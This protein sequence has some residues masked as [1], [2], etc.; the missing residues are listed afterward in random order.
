MVI[1]GV[2][3]FKDSGKDTVADI[4][5]KYTGYK[6]V[7]M[8]SSLKD[9]V[10]TMFNWDRELLE[11]RT[12][13]SRRWREEVDD[14]WTHLIAS[15]GIFSNDS[16]I[17]PRIALQRI[18]N[19]IRTNISDDFFVN[20]SIMHDNIVISDARHMNELER[21]HITIRVERFSYSN[22]EIDKMD[23]SEK[24]HLSFTP[25]FI[26]SNNGGLSQLEEKV[27]SILR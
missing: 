10:A 25:N 27:L 2:C 12:D 9:I 22:D 23:I 11:G 24:E 20:K 15:R 26:I 1:I 16:T 13:E 5:C 21:C 3:G 6:R 4:I 14:V 8:A 17:T 19:M 18:G 7:S